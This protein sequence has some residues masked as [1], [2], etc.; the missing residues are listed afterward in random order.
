MMSALLGR[1]IFVAGQDVTFSFKRVDTM[2][3]QTSWPFA[4][5]ESLQ[6]SLDW[7]LAWP[8][9]PNTG[10]VGYRRPVYVVSLEDV[11]GLAGPPV[12]ALPYL[13]RASPGM[14]YKNFILAVS[15]TP[16]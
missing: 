3:P 6:L 14:S 16:Y 2:M 7:H 10:V 12:Q 15:Y 8:F 4:S 5:P 9:H 11:G 1:S 13:S